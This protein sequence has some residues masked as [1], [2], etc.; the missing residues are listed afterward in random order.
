MATDSQ[1]SQKSTTKEKTTKAAETNN[2]LQ[3]DGHGR[4]RHQGGCRGRERPG[5]SEPDLVG[6]AHPAHGPVHPPGPDLPGR[7]RGA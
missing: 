6:A 3:G 1:D 2:G 7:G 5:C 4:N